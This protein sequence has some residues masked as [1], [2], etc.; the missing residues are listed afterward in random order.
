MILRDC[1]LAGQGGPDRRGQA[2]G[3]GGDLRSGA[4]MH[5]SAAGQQ[6]R[7][8]GPAQHLR[9]GGDVS[10]LGGWPER[11]E[12]TET[13]RRGPRRHRLGVAVEH[14]LG[15]QQRNRSWPA[16]GCRSE[17]LPDEAGHGSR[18]R[19]AGQPLRHWGQ[20]SRLVQGLRGGG[21]VPVSRQPGGQVTHQSD[22]RHRRAQSLAEAR[23]QL[24]RTR[25]HG[26]VTDAHSP[27]H[28]RVAIG[29]VR[30]GSLVTYQHMA[31]GGRPVQDG[32]VQGQRL[33]ARHAEHVADAVLGQQPRQQG[34]A[35][36]A[37]LIH[38]HDWRL[39]TC[40]Q[41]SKYRVQPFA[42][43]FYTTRALSSSRVFRL[44]RGYPPGAG[45]WPTLRGWWRA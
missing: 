4:R 20:Q 19:D 31:K 43:C 22:H 23:G 45:G 1:A 42:A 32:V 38:V 26:R 34:P 15:Q 29:G 21:P 10:R 37:R 13:R 18:V 9:H 14:V 17:R 12:G 2:R 30:R 41:S 40:A 7:P 3:Q 39:L 35:V 36:T 27:A 44:W 25:P 16:G 24:G 11:R 5:D 8:S 28:P 33:A 6:E